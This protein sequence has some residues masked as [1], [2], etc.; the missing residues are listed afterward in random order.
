MPTKKYR[1][2]FLQGI[3]LDGAPLVSDAFRQAED[4]GLQVLAIGAYR[5]ELRDFAF[6]QN[7]QSCRGVFAKYRPDALPHVGKPGGDEREIQLHR[8]E[9]IIEKNHFL[10]YAR[11][12]VLVFQTHR[13][14]CSTRQLGQ[15]LTN[16]AGGT[17][18]FAPILQGESLQRLADGNA[19]AKSIEI[20]FA[21][22]HEQMMA[23]HPLSRS[24]IR[25]LADG[26]G[27]TAHIKITPPRRR[28]LTI[29][30]QDTMARLMDNLDVSLAK[31]KLES[32]GV[33]HCVDLI[34]DRLL[35]YR[36][37]E[38]NGKYPNSQEMFNAL[39]ESYDE[40]KDIIDATVAEVPDEPR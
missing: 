33:D 26:G 10:F 9:E 14:G 13:E 2:E 16:I 38:L 30:V 15:Y 23:D 22:P 5:F 39:R 19:R 32:D 34:A 35:D 8:D 24:L 3:S 40:H 17:I 31:V 29:D 21:R 7:G 37:V 4:E 36:E 1:I 27:H 12:Q 28:H 20:T 6:A 25:M 18:A 11:R